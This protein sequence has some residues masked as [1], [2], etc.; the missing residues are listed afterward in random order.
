MA[1]R[2]LR[3]SEACLDPATTTLLN[4]PDGLRR[5]ANIGAEIWTL[6]RTVRS[7]GLAGI[8]HATPAQ[9]RLKAVLQTT[10]TQFNEEPEG[11][12]VW[13]FKYADACWLN[14]KHSVERYWPKGGTTNADIK[15]A[16]LCERKA[17]CS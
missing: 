8:E 5:S 1:A 14:V 15:V 16:A 17:A 7:T 6:M 11:D 12:S 2:G 10:Q 9:F 4:A 3:R 13:Q